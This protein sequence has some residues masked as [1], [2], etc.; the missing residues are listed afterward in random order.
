LDHSTRLAF[1]RTWLAAERTLQAWVRT[2]ASLIT[3]GFAIFSFFAAPT[4]PG[5]HLSSPL[6]PRIF[7][8]TLISIGLASLCGAAFERRQAARVM[9][10]Y[11][12]DIPGYS[13]ALIV[14]TLVAA[15]GILALVL[16]LIKT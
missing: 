15:L 3:F 12:A 4:G 5:R 16:L 6:G 10:R 11:Y 13:L 1:E 7:S 9:K 14:G 8:I 2:S